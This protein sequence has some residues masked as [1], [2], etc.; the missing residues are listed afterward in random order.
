M[1]VSTLRWGLYSA[2]MM[3]PISFK[4][5]CNVSPV[6]EISSV[7]TDLVERLRHRG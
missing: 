4:R 5:S 2:Y 1:S 6:P 3:L 7:I